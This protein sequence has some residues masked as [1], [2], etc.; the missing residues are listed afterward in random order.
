[1]EFSFDCVKALNAYDSP[2]GIVVIDAKNLQKSGHSM[3]SSSLSF[4]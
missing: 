2:D 1:M 4:Y 3:H